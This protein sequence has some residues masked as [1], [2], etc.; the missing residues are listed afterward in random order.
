MPAAAAQYDHTH[1][2]VGA[3]RREL[4]AEFVEHRLVER[5]AALRPIEPHRR[6]PACRHLHR[7]RL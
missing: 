1:L 7:Y 5:I 4:V 2:V 6:D 3:K